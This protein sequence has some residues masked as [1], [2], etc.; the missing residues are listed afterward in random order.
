MRHCVTMKSR[1]TLCLQISHLAWLGGLGVAHSQKSHY[2]KRR[3]CKTIG[4]TFTPVQQRLKQS[5]NSLS[6]LRARA[7]ARPPVYEVVTLKLDFNDSVAGR[8]FQAMSCGMRC[9]AL[10]RGHAFHRLSARPV[11]SVTSLQSSFVM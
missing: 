4:R 11:L 3:Q 1:S 9:P 7:T 8:S 5:Q 10:R 2:P 6:P